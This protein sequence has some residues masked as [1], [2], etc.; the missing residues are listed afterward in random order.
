MVVAAAGSWLV[1][2]I[3]VTAVFTGQKVGWTREMPQRRHFV[4]A[5]IFG[6]G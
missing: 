3:G 6:I 4:G 2:R 5:L 1:R